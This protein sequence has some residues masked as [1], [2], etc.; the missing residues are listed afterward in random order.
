MGCGP[1]SPAPSGTRWPPRIHFPSSP[2]HTSSHRPAPHLYGLTPTQTCRHAHVHPGWLPNSPGLVQHER[3]CP[4]SSFTKNFKQN[5]KASTGPSVA[6]QV[7]C[8]QS[9][10]GRLFVVHPG[11]LQGELTPG[12]THAHMNIHSWVHM[13]R[14]REASKMTF[15]GM[16]KCAG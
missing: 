4:C 1:H 15:I 2:L 13:L 6:A 7:M 12:H 8:Q 10:A 16:R 11:A 9:Q 14:C 5:I 3:V